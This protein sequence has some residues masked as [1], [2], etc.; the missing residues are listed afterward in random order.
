MRY[1]GSSIGIV[2]LWFG[3]L[4]FFPNFSPAEA[5]ATDTIHT[6][7]GGV[8]PAETALLLLAIW[9][10]A[11]GILLLFNLFRRPVIG[12]ALLHMAFTFSP[13]F[14]FPEASFTEAPFKFTLVGQYIVKNLVIIGALLVLWPSSKP[15]LTEGS[16]EVTSKVGVPLG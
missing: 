9:E 16:R 11:V 10:V 7:F 14:L 2:Y 5:L 1:L 4:K 8:L 3:A 13:L 12:M 6:L 15:T